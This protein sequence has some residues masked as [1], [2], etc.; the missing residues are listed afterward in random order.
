MEQNLG[1]LEF[2]GTSS[3]NGECPRVFRTA[4]GDL[5]VQGYRVTDQAALK[6]LAESYGGLPDGETAVV[7]PA[8]LA[9]FFP[10]P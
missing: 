1:K 8:S 7:I 6:Q 4:G 5:L 2:L 9:Q 3:T 10:R